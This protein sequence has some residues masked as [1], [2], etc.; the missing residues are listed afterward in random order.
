MI[1]L[2]TMS[3]VRS[4]DLDDRWRWWPVTYCIKGLYNQRSHEIFQ[5]LHGGY[6]GSDALQKVELYGVGGVEVR[7]RV[8]PRLAGSPRGTR[9][10][11]SPAPT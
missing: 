4:S 8:W 3:T 5:Y 1:A 7:V 9:D 6:R 2:V 10:P 11:H